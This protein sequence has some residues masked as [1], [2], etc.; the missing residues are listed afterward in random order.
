MMPRHEYRFCID[1]FTPA[2]LPMA[3]LAEYMAELAV[4]L[5]ETERVHFVRLEEGS[6]VLVQEIEAPATV[7][8]E[9][10][11]N[12]VRLGKAPPDAMRAFQELNRKL[13][14]DNAIGVLYAPQGA[15]I[16]RFP[17]RERPRS[18]IYPSFRQQ[19]SLDGQLVRI[20]GKD[21][22]VH[23]TLQDGT[24]A[25]RCELTRDMAR[26]LAPHLYGP[27]LRVFGDGRWRR[28]PEGH[29]TLEQFRA[30]HFQVLDDYSWPETIT[31]L[32]AIE[33]SEWRKLDD[34]FAELRRIR[35]GSGEAP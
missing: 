2:T 7:T 13:A 21:E 24:T 18:L 35:E 19:G 1:A 8:V 26:A 15:E 11:I 16:I 23:A 30:S 3:R 27:T 10:R 32:R 9:E 12:Q 29:W 17:G 33:G 4:L 20:G 34:P 28:D 31:H 14:N 22:T 5:G 25:N 6:T